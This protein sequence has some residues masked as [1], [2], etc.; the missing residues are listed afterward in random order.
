MP[1]KL[2]FDKRSGLYKV[3][4][5][6]IITLDDILETIYELEKVSSSDKLIYVLIDTLRQTSK[7]SILDADRV[8]S[9]LS[10]KNRVRY[11]IL[12]TDNHLSLNEQEIIEKLASHRG[13]SIRVFTDRDVA[14]NWL[15]SEH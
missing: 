10:G 15:I 8:A 13:K 5:S 12:S 14:V 9:A 7:L 4:A 11:A 2:I 1:N 6:G 3:E